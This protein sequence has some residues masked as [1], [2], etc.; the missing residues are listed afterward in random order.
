MYTA[1]NA[2]HLSGIVHQKGCL[3]F[4]FC[5]VLV[6]NHKHMFLTKNLTTQNR[7]VELS[8]IVLTSKIW[9]HVP[10]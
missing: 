7:H 5:D 9:L 4:H 1:Y 10:T 6:S 8:K 2:I 3:N